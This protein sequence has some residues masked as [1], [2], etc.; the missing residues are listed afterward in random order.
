MIL[1]LLGT[2]DKEFR[3][4]LEAVQKEIN[5]KTITDK[6][7]VQAGCTKFESK[8]MEIFDL[9]PTD[10]FE[11]FID[12][13]DIIIS[14][15]GV[16]SIITALKKGKKVIATP[17]LKQHKEHVNDHQVQIIEKMHKEGYIKGLFNLT[18]LAEILEEIKNFIPKQFESNTDNI[19]SV[20]EE[21]IEAL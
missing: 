7:I 16:G 4:L 18:K 6:V 21:Y 12:K 10:K 9:I 20:I 13:A 8:D 19:I 17:R 1:V 3:R 14:H 5:N 15:G 2:Q 11:N